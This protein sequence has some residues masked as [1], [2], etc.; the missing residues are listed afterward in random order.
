MTAYFVYPPELTQAIT[1]LKSKIMELL[2]AEPLITKTVRFLDNMV[3]VIENQEQTD[4]N[5]RDNVTN[6]GSELAKTAFPALLA[7]HNSLSEAN[8]LWFTLAVELARQAPLLSKNKNVLYEFLQT[9]NKNTSSAWDECLHF[10]L[11]NLPIPKIK[12]ILPDFKKIVKEDIY[13]YR[14]LIT[15]TILENMSLSFAAHLGG[16]TRDNGQIVRLDWQVLLK[17]MIHYRHDIS[18]LSLANFFIKC[19]LTSELIGA[20]RIYRIG[21]EESRVAFNLRRILH[22]AFPEKNYLHRNITDSSDLYSLEFTEQELKNIV[23]YFD[24]AEKKYQKPLLFSACEKICPKNVLEML[25]V[26]GATIESN[27]QHA[28]FA[29]INYNAV[30]QAINII[31]FLTLAQIIKFRKEFFSLLP[32]KNERINA[33]LTHRLQ[34]IT[35]EKER[36]LNIIDPNHMVH[37][38]ADTRQLPDTAEFYLNYLLDTFDSK[39]KIVKTKMKDGTFKEAIHFNSAQKHINARRMWGDVISKAHSHNKRYLS[40]NKVLPSLYKRL[41]NLGIHPKECPQVLRTCIHFLQQ[42]TS[43]VVT[44][45][46][47]VPSTLKSYQLLNIYEAKNPRGRDSSYL[48]K[49]SD[50]EM[51][52]FR[53]IASSEFCKNDLAMPR[54]GAL[55]ALSPEKYPAAITN[56]G[57][58]FVV[59]KDI[60]KFN[61]LFLPQDSMVGFLP[62]QPATYL[63]LEI[64]L[65]QCNDE[66]FDVLVKWATT[67]HLPDF[68]HQQ[69]SN[70]CSYGYMEVLLPPVDLLNPDFVECYYFANE[71][72]PDIID[73]LKKNNINVHIKTSDPYKNC[74]IEL[75]N[76]IKAD[77]ADKLAMIVTK[78]PTAIKRDNYYNFILLESALKHASKNILNYLLKKEIAEPTFNKYYIF[79]WLIRNQNIANNNHNNDYFF[80][81]VCDSIDDVDFRFSEIGGTLLHQAVFSKNIIAVE[82]LLEKGANIHVCDNKNIRADQISGDK[83]IAAFKMEL[84]EAIKNEN[85]DCLKGYF[86]DKNSLLTLEIHNGITPVLFALKMKKEKALFFLLDCCPEDSQ[87]AINLRWDRSLLQALQEAVSGGQ[88]HLAHKIA[89]KYLFLYKYQTEQR[90]PSHYKRRLPLF[91]IGLGYCAGEKKEAINKLILYRNK[92]ISIDELL[93]FRDVLANGESDLICQGLGIDFKSLSAQ[94]S[95]MAKI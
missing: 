14:D 18:N 87:T 77:D 57:D 43:L 11:N 37:Y 22:L 21:Y 59:L 36:A 17:K 94:K 54:Y 20:N 67:G 46:N 83:I 76:A 52:L 34:E 95:T 42:K 24:K 61:A 48:N 45:R 58:S 92:K 51:E 40:Q 30:E 75:E 33:A 93:N 79:S 85:I 4:K 50:T 41:E 84:S 29:A 1:A 35:A 62:P 53:A 19:V 10:A 8:V 2:A 39:Y 44:F 9:I 91:N 32:I 68:F 15:G 74:Q 47:H 69:Y 12:E 72:S 23:S 78:Y 26:L 7:A 71:Q 31:Q 56:Y 88:A 60:L 64:L 86:N 55:V 66:R 16:Q 90:E 89:D 13:A 28:L 63:N 3:I 70:N 27:N 5:E 6:A 49:R 81:R 73:L 38:Q 82:K 80:D 65:L 25:I